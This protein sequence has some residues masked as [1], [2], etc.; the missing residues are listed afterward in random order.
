MTDR[1]SQQIVASERSFKVQGLY[2]GSWLETDPLDMRV[3][4][5]ESTLDVYV[6]QLQFT[7]IPAVP[8]E[9]PKQIALMC[10]K[11]FL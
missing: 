10:K 7:E 5:G 1:A 6:A 8:C 4:Q 11:C 2:N 3:S 9:A